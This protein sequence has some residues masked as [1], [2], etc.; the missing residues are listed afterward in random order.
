MNLFESQIE[1]LNLSPTAKNCVIELRKVCLENAVDGMP[2]GLTYDPS[3]RERE[4]KM[5]RAIDEALKIIANQANDTTKQGDSVLPEFYKKVH[6][7]RPTFE[8]T[9]GKVGGETLEIQAPKFAQRMA[10]Q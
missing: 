3:K 7:Y 1:K 6:E 9:W 5:F 4:S 10:L 8:K 2:T